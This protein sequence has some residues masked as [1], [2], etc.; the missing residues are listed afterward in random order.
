MELSRL[1]GVDIKEIQQNRAK[2]AWEACREFDCIV[3]LKGHETIIAVPSG[4][5]FLNH[6]GNSSLAKAGAGDILTGMI[7]G[8]CAQGLSLELAACCAAYIHGLAGEI[9]SKS[10]TEYCVLASEIIKFIPFAMKN[11]LSIQSQTPES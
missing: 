5:I 3:L 7:A 9:A 8:F 11:I 4:K 10:L 6:T 2:W 1:M